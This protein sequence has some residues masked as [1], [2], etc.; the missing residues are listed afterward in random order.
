M[1]STAL[2]VLGGWGEDGPLDSVQILD[3]ET[4]SWSQGPSLPKPRYGHTCLLTEVAGSMG[5][6]VAGGALTGNEVI[7]LDM[8]TMKWRDLPRLNYKIGTTFIY[9]IA[10]IRFPIFSDGHKLMLV[11][12]VPTIFSWENIEQFDGK[13]IFPLDIF[14][15][16]D[17]AG[18]SWTLQKFRLSQSRSAFTMTSVP[19]HLVRGCL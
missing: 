12:G 10:C 5:V 16:F 4:G 13:W 17:Y 8:G 9:F 19:G 15:P 3:M 2:M 7:F 11:E 18:K 14:V 6:M 1:N